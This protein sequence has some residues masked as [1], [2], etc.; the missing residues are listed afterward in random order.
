[1][2]LTDLR[3]HW[4]RFGEEDP[5]WAVLTA[6]DR[7]HGKWDV[8]EFFYSGIVEVDRV[9]D[10]VG[11]VIPAESIPTGRALD[12]GC[13]VGRATQALAGRFEHVD[14]VDIAAPMVEHARRYN[15]YGD[16][17]AYH[18]NT[19]PDLR[20]FAN[21]TFDLAYSAHV[22]QH[23]HPRYAEVYVKEF[24]RVLKP[25]GVALFE[26]PT[27]RVE[28][29]AEPLPRSA[30]KAEIEILG[31]PAELRPG[32]TRS[33]TA[34]VRNAG[35]T[36]WPATGTADGW[37]HVTVGN[38]WRRNRGGVLTQDDG[39]GRLPGDVAPGATAECTLTITAPREPGAYRLELDL[40]QEGVSW[41]ADRGS[42]TALT[43]VRVRRPLA[44]RW[45][46]RSSE[47]A[48]TAAAAEPIME[49]YGTP[50][51]TVR[52]WI[53]TARGTV[54]GSFNW[55][56][57]SRETSTDWRRIGYVARRA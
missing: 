20:L 48:P 12:F 55:D 38:H 11:Q 44:E 25:G 6:P 52:G 42:K 29:S 1:M 19:D 22:L 35:D 41:F 30:F 17:C 14:G 57:I 5:L 28:G 16:R 13:G 2:E 23:M 27:Q 32:E 33:I 8:K 54:L 51:E 40:V 37:H 21:A 47:G 15:A 18:V 43:A 53:R 45:R 36:T 46:G 26:I 24:F 56:E 4:E 7:R 50:D 9:F 39:R 3:R 49:M 31:V 34:R 10:K